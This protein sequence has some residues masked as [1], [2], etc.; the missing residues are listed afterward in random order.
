MPLPRTT[1]FAAWLL[2]IQLVVR[3]CPAEAAESY[4]PNPGE[5]HGYRQ[6]TLRYRGSDDKERERKTLIWYPT[7]AEAKEYSYRGQIGFVTEDAEVAPGRHPLI[8]FSHGFLG[9]PDQSIFLTEGLARR[10]YIVAAIGHAD[11]LFAKRDQPLAAPNFSDGKSWTEDK[12]RDRREDVVA[13]LDHLL[14]ECDQRESSWFGRIDGAAIGA[15]GHS[16]GG[17]TTLGLIGGWEKATEKRIKA[18]VGPCARRS[19]IGRHSSRSQHR[20]VQTPRRHTTS[21]C[22]DRQL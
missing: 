5:Q 21:Q 20:S 10:G 22:Q 3:H 12:F 11:G 1:T 7:L 15:A 17:Y 13:L 8:L 19:P 9:M 6:T 18:N 4:S 16:L 14:S 2:L